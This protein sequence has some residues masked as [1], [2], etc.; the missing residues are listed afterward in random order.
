MT[1]SD[2]IFRRLT[3]RDALARAAR[4]TGLAVVG[5]ITAR[6]LMRGRGALS[7]DV[8][9]AAS[10]CARCGV[11]DSCRLPEAELQRSRGL[12]LVTPVRR[13][14]VSQETQVEALCD[15]GRRA[16]SGDGRDRTTD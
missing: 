14:Q 12:G 6:L 15:D 7:S 5:A 9:A 4:W 8:A 13:S 1:D 11:F 3:R 2:N 10:R 16:A